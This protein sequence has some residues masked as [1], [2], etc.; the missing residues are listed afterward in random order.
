MQ[1]VNS[2]LV[3][4]SHL[5]GFIYAEEFHVDVSLSINIYR[6][7]VI[8]WGEIWGGIIGSNWY[9]SNLPLLIMVRFAFINSLACT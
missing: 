2:G 8:C 7:K 1:R 6:G 9:T 3:N 5:L 4:D